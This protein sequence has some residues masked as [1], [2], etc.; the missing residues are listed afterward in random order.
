MPLFSPMMMWMV[1]TLYMQWMQM[2]FVCNMQRLG[3]SDLYTIANERFEMNGSVIDDLT[4]HM[5]FHISCF[6]GV[7]EGGKE[8]TNMHVWTTR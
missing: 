3:L 1:I 8:A 4:Y 6:G 2:P 5:G 7:G